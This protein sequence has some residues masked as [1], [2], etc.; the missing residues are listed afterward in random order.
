M[1]LIEHQT[2]LWYHIKLVTKTYAQVYMR[3]V[4]NMKK[5]KKKK[6]K[7]SVLRKKSRVFLHVVETIG[8]RCIWNEIVTTIVISSM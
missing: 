1:K 5:K 4:Q 2:K 8:K 6:K 7:L 3:H